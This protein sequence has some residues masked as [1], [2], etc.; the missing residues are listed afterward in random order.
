MRRIL[1]GCMN[2]LVCVVAVIA[3]LGCGHT[4]RDVSPAAQESRSWPRHIAGRELCVTTHQ[5]AIYAHNPK[6]G[7]TLHS[8]LGD[9]LAEAQVRYGTAIGRGVVLAIE[10]LEEPV[11]ELDAWR[12]QNVDRYREI[13]WSD[14][15]GSGFHGFGRPYCLSNEPYFTES[16][17]LPVDVALKLALLSEKDLRPQWI[18]VLTTDAHRVTAFG[19]ELRRH[20]S[21]AHLYFWKMIGFRFW[22]RRGAIDHDLMVL[23]R[24]EALCEAVV[25]A[26]MKKGPDKTKALIDLRNDIDEE[27]KYLFL[28]RPVE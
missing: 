1:T 9:E 22:D 21:A 14:A 27:W 25:N 6:N 28:N 2:R 12:A 15:F 23:R 16:Y 7:E 5:Y 20:F 10:S 4:K 3:L 8:W 19:R 13:H 24:H 18:C 26:V 11:T 17:A